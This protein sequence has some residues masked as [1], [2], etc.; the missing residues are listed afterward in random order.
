MKNYLFEADF[1]TEKTTATKKAL[2]VNMPNADFTEFAAGVFYE[3][4]EKDIKRYL[5]YGVYWWALKD[6]LLRQGY[7]VG[8]VTDVDMAGWYKGATDEETLVAADLFYLDMSNKVMVDNTNWTIENGQPDYVLYDADMER[9]GSITQSS[10]G[11]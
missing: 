4:L 3:R 2:A 7:G 11:D 8:D 5:V 9:R 6:V 1:L 10:L